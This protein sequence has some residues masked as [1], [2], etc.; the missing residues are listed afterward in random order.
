[1]KGETMLLDKEMHQ[2]GSALRCFFTS[3]FICI[4]LLLLP[5]GGQCGRYALVIGNSDYEYEALRNPVNDAKAMSRTLKDVD[6]EGTL[7]K[8]GDKKEMIKAIQRFSSRLSKR[9]EALFFY[10]G[11]AMQVNNENYLLPVGVAAN[12]NI[13]VNDSFIKMTDVI[14]EMHKSNMSIVILDACRNNPYNDYYM[15]DSSELTRSSRGIG[16]RPKAGLAPPKRAMGTLIAYST[17][18]G[19][20]AYDGDERNSVFTMKLVEYIKEPGL[21]LENVFKKVRVA[22]ADATDKKQIPWDS[23]SITGQFYFVKPV[24][25]TIKKVDRNVF[26]P[27]F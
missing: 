4:F 13:N 25:N 22:V 8:N 11:H 20:V 1:M 24:S 5:V 9:D 26:T 14:N 2:R 12:E 15:Q 17:D 21:P 10:A 6:F 7:V 3:I 27:V 19:N 23:S 16:V 18:I